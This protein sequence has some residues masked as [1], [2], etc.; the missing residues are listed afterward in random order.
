M[1]RI[2]KRLRQKMAAHAKPDRRDRRSAFRPDDSR[3]VLAL[4]AH[5]QGQVA[6]A[7][8]H[9]LALLR[10]HPED[11]DALHLLGVM[12]SELGRYAQAVTWIEAA[13][14]LKPMFPEAYYNLGNAFKGLGRQ[15]Q[16]LASFRHALRLR[17][18]FAEAC[19]NMGTVWHGQSLWAE[20]VECYRQALSIRPDYPE[21]LVNF[22]MALQSW[23][24]LAAAEEKFKQAI[25]IRPDYP[26]AWSRWGVTLQDQ[27]DLPAAVE[28]YRQALMLR[29]NQAEFL[30]HLGGA[31]L[32]MERLTEAEGYLHQ[33]LARQPRHP[34]ALTNLGSLLHKQGR[35][36]EALE[37]FFMAQ[38][39]DP[40]FAEAYFGAS[41]VQLLLGDYPS[42]WRHYEWRWRTRGFQPHGQGQPVWD[43]G[44][45]SGRT[46]LIHCEQG[47]GD[48]IQFIRFV[49]LVKEKGGR[50]V[51]LCPPPLYRLFSRMASIDLLVRHGDSV[52]P[53]DCQIPLM[54]LA[55]LLGTTPDTI[56]AQGPYL[57]V[58]KG[59]GQEK[60][61]LPAEFP[62]LKVGL[63][64]RGSRHFKN[65][66]I[67]SMPVSMVGQ[68]LTLEGCLFVSLQKEMTTEERAW[69]AAKRH[70]VDLSQELYD[71]ADTAR[72]LASLDLVISVDTAVLHL[73][74]AMGIPVWGVI[75]H[76][77]DWRWLLG[78]ADSPWYPSLRLF[79]QSRPGSWQEVLE[80]MTERLGLVTAG[81]MPLVW[82]V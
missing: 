44:V 14:R 32:S 54:S 42:G 66:H 16:A 59:P 25:A 30:S 38:E 79:R 10:D 69:M 52:P 17:P 34:E 41:L 37:A 2:M 51:V 63:V 57:Q 49:P 46:L 56:P 36:H 39:A 23:G 78:R 45:L 75:P 64:W 58:E 27:G 72:I 5:R 53:C 33:A 61:F 6:E 1:S 71:F 9:C 43:G 60:M 19:L 77:P 82:P 28:K 31:L 50:I 65:D 76:V 67:R 8:A 13:V 11:P 7:E 29:P 4:T 22:G 55:G 3:L 48:S 68:L 70:F 18:D 20:A 47:L 80:E 26:E 21:A 35:L 15:D 12:A 73:A 81:K 24:N 74:G 40:N 62:G